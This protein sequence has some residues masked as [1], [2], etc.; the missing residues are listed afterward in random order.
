MTTISY[1]QAE[2]KLNI[3]PE[4]KRVENGAKTEDLRDISE[5]VYIGVDA[6]V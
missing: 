4:V 2:A 1:L 6:Y 3:R 5:K